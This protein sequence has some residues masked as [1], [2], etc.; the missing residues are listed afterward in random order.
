MKYILI[1][2]AIFLGSQGLLQAQQALPLY[3]TQARFAH[4]NKAGGYLHYANWDAASHGA[5]DY[6]AGE[7]YYC[8]G[9]NQLSLH[10]SQQQYIVDGWKYLGLQYAKILPLSDAPL[11]DY[12]SVGLEAGY[13]AQE[14]NIPS[15]TRTNTFTELAAP[16]SDGKVSTTFALGGHF[17]GALFVNV[18]LHHFWHY[19]LG[20]APAGEKP[21]ELYSLLG[22]TF[23]LGP[24]WG[25][26]PV[27]SLVFNPDEGFQ[28]ERLRTELQIA[29]HSAGWYMAATPVYV[30]GYKM[31]MVLGISPA[32][33]KLGMY[34]GVFRYQ[35]A[36][37]SE[38]VSTVSYQSP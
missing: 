6:F 3:H 35:H 30:P 33:W 8:R 18:V 5:H 21:M 25:L 14:K 26:T 13:L 31:G 12:I 29:Y 27:A 9:T 10:A 23:S 24:S 11:Q 4:P 1:F 17:R 38:F 36:P 32:H 7:L 16:Y 20:G 37:F 15:L 22:Y 28:A 2:V 19:S 34:F